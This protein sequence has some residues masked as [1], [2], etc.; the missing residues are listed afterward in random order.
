MC[1]LSAHIK[2]SIFEN[3][4]SKIEKCVNT[5]SIFEKIFS[6]MNN[7]TCVLRTHINRYI[8]LS[9]YSSIICHKNVYPTH[10]KS[11]CKKKGHGS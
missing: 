8:D 1:V 10:L 2:S 11:E 3:I 4:Y 7:L 6:K 5:F 9:H